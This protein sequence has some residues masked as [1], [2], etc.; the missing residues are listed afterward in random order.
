MTTNCYN[1]DMKAMVV[2]STAVLAG[3]PINSLIEVFS[4]NQNCENTRENYRR[5]VRLFYQA[6]GKRAAEVTLHDLIAYK[7]QLENEGLKPASIAKKLT[8]LRRLF[9][10]LY[11]QGALPK[12]PSAGLKLPKV[13]NES[14]KDILTL[15]EANKLLASVD[16]STA[17]GKRD[18]AVLALLTVNALRVVELHRANVGDFSPKEGCWALRVKGKGMKIADVRI[19]DDV[20][21]VIDAYLETRGDVQP[22]DPLFL[23]T[24]H[25]S[26]ERITR[27]TLQRIV[28]RYLKKI[29]VQRPNLSAHSLRHSAITHVVEAGASLLDAQEFARHSSPVVTQQTY[30]H[31]RDRLKRSVVLI[32][33]I[34]CNCN[35]SDWIS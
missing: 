16:T 28:E 21:Q 14:T 29:G 30:I 8:V 15:A 7:E 31:R 12:N 25:R 20:K 27:R 22:S 17:R 9:T 24:N 6:L 19:R 1:R 11:E 4:K 5:E 3:E 35:N 2:P 32:N 13:T 26:G 18:K 33:P 34:V 10:F 23:G